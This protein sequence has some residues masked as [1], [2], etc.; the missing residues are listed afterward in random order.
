VSVPTDKVPPKTANPVPKFK[1]HG[2]RYGVSPQID[3]S[4]LKG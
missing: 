2:P 4:S 1:K 3:P